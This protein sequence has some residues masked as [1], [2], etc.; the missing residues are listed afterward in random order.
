M[1]IFNFRQSLEKK[2]YAALNK[3]TEAL[4]AVH[5][6]VV[7]KTANIARG[8]EPP[9]MSEAFGLRESDRWS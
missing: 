6:A 7:G 9:G 5:V 2:R 4:E 3:W 8:S 1:T